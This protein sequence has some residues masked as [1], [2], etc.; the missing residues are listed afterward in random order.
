VCHFARSK[1]TPKRVSGKVTKWQSLEIN[2]RMQSLEVF[3]LKLFPALRF[4]LFVLSLDKL[5]MTKQKGF[6]LQSGLGLCHPF[7]LSLSRISPNV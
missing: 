6:S 2:E 5:G 1:D 4:N 7:V 3:Y